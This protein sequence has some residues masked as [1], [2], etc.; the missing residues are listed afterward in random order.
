MLVSSYAD[1]AG[2]RREILLSVSPLLSYPR[3]EHLQGL[4]VANESSPAVAAEGLQ[5]RNVYVFFFSLQ[6]D[7]K[8]RQ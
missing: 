8:K 7:G 4:K 1:L 3:L 5:K 6:N 2:S